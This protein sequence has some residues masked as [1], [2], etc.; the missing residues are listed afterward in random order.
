MKKLFL[1]VLFALSVASTVYASDMNTHGVEC[2]D[3]VNLSECS[4]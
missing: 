3:E 1:A 2:W 4:K